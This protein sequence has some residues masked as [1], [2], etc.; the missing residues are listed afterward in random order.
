MPGSRFFKFPQQMGFGNAPPLP[1]SEIP[2][3]AI[4][5]SISHIW[6]DGSRKA[7]NDEPDLSLGVF[8]QP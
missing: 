6:E 4:H 1:G 8:S 3:L 5:K 2:L 7:N